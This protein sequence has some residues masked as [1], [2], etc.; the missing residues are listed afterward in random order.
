MHDVERGMQAQPYNELHGIKKVIFFHAFN[1]KLQSKKG[2]EEN[3][4]HHY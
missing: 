1:A 2:K 3:F 4:L